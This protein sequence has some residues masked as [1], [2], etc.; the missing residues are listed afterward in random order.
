ML[1]RKI[2]KEAFNASFLLSNTPFPRMFIKLTPG[3]MLI[4]NEVER[5][6]GIFTKSNILRNILKIIN[7]FRL[8]F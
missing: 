4:N 6:I 3:D 2:P 5:N 1:D 8:L 7:S